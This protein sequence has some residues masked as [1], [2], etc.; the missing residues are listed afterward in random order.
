[1]SINTSYILPTH[2]VYAT[3]FGQSTE[4]VAEFAEE[5]NLKLFKTGHTLVDWHIY[6]PVI[7]SLLYS[8]QLR[9]ARREFLYTYLYVA[10]LLVS[11]MIQ[12][13]FIQ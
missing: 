2:L 11:W 13:I 9:L 12:S 8:D 3:R 7:L 10:D 6:S 5:P 4:E 1:M